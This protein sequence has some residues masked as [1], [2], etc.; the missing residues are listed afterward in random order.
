MINP[1][2]TDL[3]TGNSNFTQSVN[4]SNLK[5]RSMILK[6]QTPQLENFKNGTDRTKPSTHN[7]S[8]QQYNK[9]YLEI[10]TFLLDGG[11]GSVIEKQG[12]SGYSQNSSPMNRFGEA[13]FH[14]PPQ[15]QQ[16]DF[17]TVRTGNKKTGQN[18]RLASHGP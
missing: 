12:D 14:V 17:S 6:S 9:N 15:Q 3:I 1:Q 18:S 4:Q 8:I 10:D 16:R 5:K 2:Q 13:S 11:T 7:G